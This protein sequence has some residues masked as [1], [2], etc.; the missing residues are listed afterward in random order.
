MNDGILGM[1]HR[2]IM[3]TYLEQISARDDSG[4]AAAAQL[5]AANI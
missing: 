1:N 5:A 4:K 2:S 3:V